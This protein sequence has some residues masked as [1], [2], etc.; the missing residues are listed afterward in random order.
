MSARL[1]YWL[2]RRRGAV[3]T[4]V[5]CVLLGHPDATRVAAAARGLS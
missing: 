5:G 2:L 3:C 1:G 4:A